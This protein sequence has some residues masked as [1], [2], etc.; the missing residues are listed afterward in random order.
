[1]PATGGTA[2][3]L[4][5][6]AAT[7]DSFESILVGAYLSRTGKPKEE[8]EGQ[9]KMD[10]IISSSEALAQGWVDSIILNADLASAPAAGQ[11]QPPSH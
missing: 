11:G 5:K 3:D 7:H 9:L 8:I 10:Q 2:D 4:R 1:M 6:D